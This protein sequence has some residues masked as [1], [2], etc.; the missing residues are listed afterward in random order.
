MIDLHTH[1]LPG[2]DDGARTLAEALA[3]ARVAESEGISC[4]VA[5]PHILDEEALQRTREIARAVDA[6]QR[7]LD[8]EGIAV[9]VVPAAEVQMRDD[10][11]AYLRA[12]LPLTINSDGRYLLLEPPFQQLPMCA[13]QLIFELLANGVTP[14]ITHPERSL[15]FRNQPELLHKMVDNGALSQLTASSLTG[16][17]GPDVRRFSRLMLEH[18]LAQIMS[19]DAHSPDRRPPLLRSGVAVAAEL[20]GEEAA[21]RLVGDNPARVLAGRAVL[22]EP[23]PVETAARRSWWSRL[24]PGRSGEQE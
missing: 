23:K 21:Q 18:G 20:I 14:I 17:M 12:G 8:E 10:L 19:S 1:I 22:R 6:L 7:A 2:F 15:G 16:M 24:V 4:M 5:S 9:K 11:V 3:I 13:E